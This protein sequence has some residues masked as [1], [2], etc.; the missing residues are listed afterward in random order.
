[1]CPRSHSRMGLGGGL[2]VNTSNISAVTKFLIVSHLQSKG[3]APED[4]CSV[5][6][7]LLVS[8]AKGSFYSTYLD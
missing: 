4:P 2:D 5:I 7:V 8:E 1:M 6:I 3:L